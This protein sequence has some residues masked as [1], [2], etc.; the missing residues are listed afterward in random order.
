MPHD[1][2]PFL[3][4]MAA[5]A[6]SQVGN[7]MT[8]VAIPWLVLETT[9]SAAQVGLTGAAIAIGW[10]APAIL[11][12]PLVDRLGLRRTS[13]AGDLVSGVTVAGIPVLQLLGVLQFWQLIML[14]FLLSSFNALGDTG[15]FAL[16]PGL[17]SRASI[18]LERSNAADRAIARVG[19]LVGPVLAGVL[20]AFIGPANVLFAD[21]GTFALSAMLVGF[22]VRSAVAAPSVPDQP[23]T[24]R[25]YGAD[26]SEGLRFVFSNRLIFS[27]ILLALV[28][29]VFD[30]P[31]VTVVLPVYAKEIFGSPSSLGLMLGSFAAGALAG[32]IL[33]GAIGRALPRRRMFLWGWL[34]VP[35]IIYGALAAQLPVAGVVLAG[36]LVGVVAGPINPILETVV[37]EN[38]P[39]QLMG[40]VFGALL[41]FAQAGIP[42][43]AAIAGLAI[44]GIGLMPT[45][46]GMG[47]IYLVVVALMFVNPAL[48][49]ME[50]AVAPGKEPLAAEAMAPSEPSPQ[51]RRCA[52]MKAGL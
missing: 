15:R 13:V 3:A 30:V 47:A 28:G 29:N 17:A 6:V 9:G 16:I 5:Q 41:A 2:R 39:P 46:A 20:I 8:A 22:G 24:R 31:L 35:L 11:G 43:G 48:R 40:R 10:V 26:L 38:T 45:I 7:M 51:A 36:V 19:Q 37:Q 4:L 23:T 52:T 18:S 34:L 42:F 25:S 44:E 1:R 27:M 12:G 50:R 14:V 49:R 33:F 21:A 32:T